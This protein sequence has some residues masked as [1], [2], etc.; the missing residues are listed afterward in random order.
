MPLAEISLAALIIAIVVSCISDVNVGFLAIA[1]AWVVGVYF[2]GM[3]VGQLVA[4]FPSQLF[5]TLTG[6]TLLFSQAQVNGTLDRIAHQSVR[7][8][9][10]NAGTIGLMFFVLALALASIGPGNIASAALVAPGVGSLRLCGGA[11]TSA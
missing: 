7:L 11:A 9:R 5:L 2:G 4:G 3:T 8:C 1:L 6:V 10:G